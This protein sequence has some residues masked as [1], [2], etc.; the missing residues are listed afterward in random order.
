[1]KIGKIVRDKK[2]QKDENKRRVQSV[3]TARQDEQMSFPLKT[4]VYGGLQFDM[5]MST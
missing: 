5:D 2:K 1:M 3:K 4:K